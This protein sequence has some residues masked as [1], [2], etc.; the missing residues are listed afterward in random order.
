MDV[1]FFY[2]ALLLYV[3]GTIA[4]LLLLSI[5]GGPLSRIATA[6][7]L[8]GF[9][10]H[11]V[12]LL[13]RLY[14]AGRPPLSNPYE[15]L[16]FFAW[17]TVL[18]YLGLEF[19]FQRKAMG[20]FVLPIILLTTVAA[21][22]LPKGTGALAPVLKGTWIWIHVTLVLLGNA[23]FALTFGVGLMYLLQERQLKS[24]SLGAIYYRLPSLEFLDMLSHRTLLVGFPLLTAG[25]ITGSIQA[26]YAWGRFLTWDPTQVLSLITWVIYAGLLQAR[27]TAGWRGRK[28]AILSIIGFCAVLVTFLGV[29]FIVGGPHA[30]N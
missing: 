13:L 2:G 4:Y 20:A 6:A 23:A 28:A 8:G 5:K 9:G 16:S 29:S 10:L 15:A 18:V 26:Q 27:M 30:F 11:T 14:V 25:L 3:V 12:A 17:A 22:V 24:K 21:S 1:T 7:T 19:R